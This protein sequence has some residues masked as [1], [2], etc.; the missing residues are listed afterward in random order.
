MTIGLGRFFGGPITRASP[1]CVHL[2]FTPLPGYWIFGMLWSSRFADRP[3]A[4]MPTPFTP[5]FRQTPFP[6]AG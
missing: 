3:S 4:V 5:G 2:I 1:V 6:G